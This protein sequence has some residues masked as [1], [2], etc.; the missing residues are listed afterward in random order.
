MENCEPATEIEIE[1]EKDE[2]TYMLEEYCHYSKDYWA[3]RNI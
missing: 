2:I 1:Y 3:V